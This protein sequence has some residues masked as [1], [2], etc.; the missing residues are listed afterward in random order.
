MKKLFLAS[1]YLHYALYH[2][3]I[4]VHHIFT[5]LSHLVLYTPG[6]NNVVPNDHVT[7][8]LKSCGTTT[9]QKYSLVTWP[10]VIIT[11]DSALSAHHVSHV[12]VRKNMLLVTR[13]GKNVTSICD[14][15]ITNAHILVAF[16][17]ATLYMNQLSILLSLGNM[18]N[19]ELLDGILIQIFLDRF[20]DEFLDDWKVELTECFSGSDSRRTW[21]TDYINAE[22]SLAKLAVWFWEDKACFDVIHRLEHWLINHNLRQHPAKVDL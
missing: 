2:V 5:W 4:Y 15:N 1:P 6:F 14:D 13:K 20:F 9:C 22:V 17:L 8:V 11:W 19:F 12:T 21:R 3:T 10:S 18:P 7:V 16:Y